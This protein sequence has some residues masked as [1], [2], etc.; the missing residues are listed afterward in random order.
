MNHA[1][2]SVTVAVLVVLAAYALVRRWWRALASKGHDEQAAAGG[3]CPDCG[4][5]DRGPGRL[6][7]GPGRTRPA[8][9]TGA[10]EQKPIAGPDGPRSF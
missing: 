5:P 4:R 6:R 3:A 1:L 7:G 2:Q 9:R 8:L 10:N